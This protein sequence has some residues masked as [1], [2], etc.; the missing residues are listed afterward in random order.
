MDGKCDCC[1]KEC[2][3]M[4]KKS[5]VGGQ[6]VIEGVMMRLNDN[7]AVAVR[8]KDGVKV[9][10][11]D[12]K[13][14]KFNWFFV[15]GIVNLIY[16]LYVGIKTLNYSASVAA[17]VEDKK[18]SSWDVVLS[19]VLGVGLAIV[20]FK[21]FPLFIANQF[22]VSN[23]SFNFIDGGVKLLVFLLYVYFISRFKDV[24]RVF[25]YHGAEHKV[26]NAYEKGVDLVVSKVQKMSTVHKRC[27]TT[28][29]F[30]VIL[31]SIVVYLFIPAYVGFWWKLGLRLALLPVIA[32]IAYE[33]LK[34][35]A[36]VRWLYPLVYPGLLIQR[37]TTKEPTDG[38][39]EVAIASMKAVS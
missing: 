4:E 17:G 13:F 29:L 37:M 5:L 19:L 34:Y 32:G 36:T 9:R 26:V 25:M 23:V 8:S 38:M 18:G 11:F 30:L 3:V 7:V 12:F 31:V 1:G 33:I 21:L 27:G 35:G 14:P 15:R 20:L 10:K 39:V 6:A 24:R 28:F 22:K 16:T 2:G